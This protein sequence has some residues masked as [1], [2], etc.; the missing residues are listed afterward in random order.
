VDSTKWLD[1]AIIAQVEISSEDESYPIE[2]ALSPG[3]GA[4]WRAAESGK[5]TIR[6]LFD[7]PQRIRT[8][9][10]EFNEAS[11]VERSQ[12]FCLSASSGAGLPK[13]IVRQQ[14]NFSSDSRT[15]IENYTVELAQVTAL[16]LVI[17]PDRSGGNARAS[18]TKMRVA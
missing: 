3:N 1:L 6:I 17:I 8:I 5:Q 13:E 11:G 14:Y 7:E 2:A 4:G 18:L 16:E 15:E 10:L 9:H 12:E